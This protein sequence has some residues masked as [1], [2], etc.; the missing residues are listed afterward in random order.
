M[1][2]PRQLPGLKSHDLEL[3]K[4]CI[5]GKKNQTNFVR[6]GHEKKFSPLEHAHSDVFCPTKVTSLGGANYFVTFLDNCT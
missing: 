2:Q 4:H 1:L 5:Y 6:M 3:C